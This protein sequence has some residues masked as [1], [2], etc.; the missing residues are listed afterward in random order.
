MLSTT[1]DIPIC[2]SYTYYK[3]YFAQFTFDSII[4]V[5]RRVADHGIGAVGA[6]MSFERM[7]YLILASTKATSSASSA[8]SS[9][10]RSPAFG[11]W[12]VFHHADRPVKQECW[13]NIYLW[14]RELSMGDRSSSMPPG[15]PVNDS[16]PRCKPP[17]KAKRAQLAPRL[18]Q[19]QPEPQIRASPGASRLER[20]A[21]P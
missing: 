17:A 18:G 13:P 21:L 16:G 5:S 20:A 10:S 8:S 4:N 9:A 11:S 1:V 2:L 19:R 3:V 6:I 7:T 15:S 14:H 12:V